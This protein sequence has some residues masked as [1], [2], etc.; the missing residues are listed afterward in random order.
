MGIMSEQLTIRPYARL[1]TMLGDQLIKNE[2]IALIELI[3]NSYDADASWVK[4][5]FVNFNEDYSTRADSKIIIEDDGCGMDESIL[6]DHWLNPATPEKLQRKKIEER[7][8]KGRFI[9]GE[10][11]IG[12]YAIFKLGK[13]ITITSRRRLKNE[14]NQFI[15]AG[16][17]IENILIYDF[18]KYDNDFLTEDGNEKILFLNDLLIDYSKEKPKRIIENEI[19]FGTIIEKRKPYGTIIEISNLKSKW[20]VDRVERIQKEVGK[21]QPIFSEKEITDFN[22]W[23]CKDGELAPFST[24]YKEELTKL[25]QEK[26][27]FRITEGQYESEN[28]TIKFFLNDKLIE[29]DF[30][31]QDIKGI[32]QFKKYFKEDNYRTECGNFKFEFYIFDRNVDSENPS[33][34]Y[35]NTNEKEIIKNHRIYL[36]RDEIR[37]MPYGDPEDDWLQIDIIRGTV[38]AAEFLSNDQL[39]GCV[40]ITQRENGNLKDK[41]NREGLIEDGAALRDF[42][43]VLQLILRYIRKKPYAQYLIEKKRKIEIDRIKHGQPSEFIEI[44]KEQNKNDNKILS[45][46]NEFEASYKR[47]KS[48]LQE[49]LNKTENLA[50]VGLS[51]ETA[52]HDVMLF[53]N[54]TLE[55]QDSIIREL[56][57]GN[58]IDKDELIS[59]LSSIRVNLSLVESQLKDIQLL[60]PSTKPKTKNINVKE[61]VDKVHQLYIRPFQKNDISVSIESTLNPLIVRTTDAVLLQVFINLFDNALYWLQTIHGE[62]KIV[63]TINGNEQRLIFSDNGPGIKPD[64][65]NYIFEAFYSGKGEDGRGLGLYIA[66]Q[67]LDRYDYT[68]TLAEFNKDRVL[69][70]AN[71]VLEFIKEG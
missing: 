20:D 23:L 30:S 39:V 34:Y 61:I 12:R 68:I 43:T 2:L 37:V 1:I 62:R 14:I 44:A 58:T 4:V 38:S 57:I 26:S 53:I 25:L 46:I 33:K 65:E 19:R 55:Q 42:I 52:S 66:R 41:T 7:T 18:S 10:K 9:Q 32:K 28:N 35:L 51:I 50:A 54:K 69:N 22:V 48:H 15:N 63:I 36:Y 29:L 27:V 40:Y 70:G 8:E 64:D 5:D 56:S 59:R 67:L 16:E 45:F 21:L 3:K 31:N 11:G 60:F 71:F 24:K 17:D 49:R 6:R 13:F 47:E